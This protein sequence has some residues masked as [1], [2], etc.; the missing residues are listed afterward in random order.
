[1]IIFVLI[2]ICGINLL[3]GN[4]TA[5]IDIS[6]QLKSKNI[7]CDLHEFVKMN[8][9]SDDEYQLLKQDLT[10]YCFDST[11]YSLICQMLFIKLRFACILPNSSRPS[12]T[13]YSIDPQFKPNCSTRKVVLINNWIWT[14]LSSDEKQQI[15]S[16]P[17]DICPK[18]TANNETLRL[19]KFFYKLPPRFLRPNTINKTDSITPQSSPTTETSTI[20]INTT[21]K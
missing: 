19:V 2:L 7:S 9:N 16:S 21:S 18:I 10:K 11:S 13:K 8:N 20:Q 17:N 1:M 14:K 4:E 3:N 15:G 6:Q 12:P 5:G